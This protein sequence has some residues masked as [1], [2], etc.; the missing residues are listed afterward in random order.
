MNKL[1]ATHLIAAVSMVV[2]MPVRAAP[3]PGMEYS[4]VTLT[5]ESQ[6]LGCPAPATRTVPLNDPAPLEQLTTFPGFRPFVLTQ[7]TQPNAFVSTSAAGN[8]LMNVGVSGVIDEAHRWAEV[9]YEQTIR[10]PGRTDSRPLT[11]QLH[12]PEIRIFTSFSEGATALANSLAWRAEASIDIFWFT[13]GKDGLIIDTG[14]P[15]QL[16]VTVD[17]TDELSSP[18]SLTTTMSSQLEALA[19]GGSTEGGQIH[20]VFYMKDVP[21]TYD[22]DAIGHT[23]DPID[24]T[25]GLAAV[26]AEGSLELAYAMRVSYTIVE[27]KVDD[28]I[29]AFEVM[30]GDPFEIGGGSVGSFNVGEAAAAVPEPASLSLLALGAVLSMV[31]RRRVTTARRTAM[32]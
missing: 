26:P 25:V 24:I 31:W 13:K 4:D 7:S 17:R 3:T 12:I 22:Y 28:R 11:V 18:S 1:L 30:I 21:G 10:N 15:L 29:S 16:G 5:I 32:G 2:A 8:G 23:F 19:A 6:C 9:V 20:D 14:N 27:A